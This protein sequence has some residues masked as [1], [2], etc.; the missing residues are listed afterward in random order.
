MAEVARP[1]KQAESVEYTWVWVSIIVLLVAWG[2]TYTQF[3]TIAM[4]AVSLAVGAT[5]VFSVRQSQ[6]DSQKKTE[7]TNPLQSP[8]SDEVPPRI[9]AINSALRELLAECEQNILAVKSTQDD[10]VH[11]LSTSFSSLRE[12]V[13]EQQTLTKSLMTFEGSEQSYAA[14]LKDFATETDETLMS[15]IDTTEKVSSSTQSLMTQVEQIYQAMPTVEKA[16]SDIDAISSQ[17]NLLALNAAIE[18]A[19]A[20]EAGRGFAVVADEVRALSTRSTEFS[21][22]ITQQMSMIGEMITN[23]EKEARFV[24]SIDLSQVTNKKDHI[25]GQ[26][27]LI[28]GKASQDL[29]VTEALS[30]LNTRFS[31]TVG[32]AIRGM[33]FG[34]I[35]GQNLEHTA[36]IISMITD[37]LD[38]HNI[39]HL[40]TQMEDYKSQL[41]A[42]GQLDHN[43]VS[44]S[45]MDAGD[46]ELF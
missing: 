38:T 16:L 35:N 25:K 3:P 28:A 27:G 19:R 2:A 17:T 29:S 23:L 37:Q 32:D 10:A 15:F 43:P 5:T 18:A 8:S 44:A 22:V 46:V 45:S 4:V 36:G 40:E 7:Q 42:K 11:T 6:H 1:F 26:L 13:E 41:V 30:S 20:G 14:H 31:A 24:A 12:L 9:R 39:S 34:D 33:Q 21:G